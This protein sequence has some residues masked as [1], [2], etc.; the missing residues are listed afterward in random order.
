[1]QAEAKGFGWPLT[2]AVLISLL[3]SVPGIIVPVFSQVFV[4]YVLVQALDDWLAPLLIGMTI[5]ALVRF[6]LARIQG[7]A[8]LRLG[9]AVTFETS[10]S[11][12]WHMLQLPI[13]FFERDGGGSHNNNRN[14]NRHVRV[15]PKT[16]I[17]RKDL[18]CLRWHERFTRFAEF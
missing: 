18:L 5:T 10:R 2:F 3:L 1:M 4:D 8:L 16:R 7:R 13:S 14:T 12:F 15:E 17:H 6:L 9:E 11:L